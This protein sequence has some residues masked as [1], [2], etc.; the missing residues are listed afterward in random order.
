MSETCKAFT[1]WFTGL[2]GS[3]K[4]TLAS[5]LQHHLEELGLH[6]I[7]L[8]GAEIRKTISVELGF[9]K[10]DRDTHIRRMGEVCELLCRNGIIA[11]A[12]AVSP[13]R[14]TRQANRQLIQR[15]VEVYCKCP[16]PVLEQRDRTHFYQRARTGEIQNVAGIDAPYEEPLD[17]EV[18]VDT[19]KLSPAEAVTRILAALGRLGYI[20]TSKGTRIYSEEE[21]QRIRNHLKKLG[22]M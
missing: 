10:V 4:S 3:G 8:D 13:G 22:Y 1:V 12:A 15:Y 6:A 7:V 19:D 2:S 5:L 14:A 9:K 18:V 11:V 16:L 17:A 21:E 20:E